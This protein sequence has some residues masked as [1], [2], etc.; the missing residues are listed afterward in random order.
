MTFAPILTLYRGATKALGPIATLWLNA[1]ARSGKEDSERLQERHGR[2]TRERPTGPL[3]WLHGASIGESGVALQIAD[4]MASRDPHLSFLISSGTRTSAELVAKRA[5]MR[6]RHVYAPVDRASA[7]RRF[8]AHWR[9]DLGVFVESDVWPNLILEAQQA[10]V[11]LALANARMSPKT[12]ARWRTWNATGERLFGAFRVALAADARTAEALSALRHAPTPVVGNLK[13]AADPPRV[14]EVQRA[15]L[16]AE[17]GARPRWLAASTHE[18]EDEIVLAA[19]AKLRETYPDALLIIAPRH[20]ARGEA[21]A[22]LAGGAPLRSKREAIGAAPVYVADT[23]GELGAF[24]ML[25][26]A[27]FVAG[28]LLPHLKGHNPIEAAK[29]GANIV[30]GPYVESFE[31]IYDALFAAHG[32]E[33]AATPDAIARAI[34]ALWSSADLRRASAQ[35]ASAI[36]ES[37]GAALDATVA[38]L[39]ALLPATAPDLKAADASA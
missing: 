15:S 32:A 12:L 7:V 25:A 23:L 8:L 10:G 33:R 13:L 5:G 27:A 22:A 24:Y 3:V 16:E 6:A 30:V 31:D 2:Y 34:A 17:I 18:G 11:P 14:D 20:P 19:H 36:V 4:A 26:P 38:Q 35:A 39:C 29:L 28:S 21:I 1:R 9:P 37:G